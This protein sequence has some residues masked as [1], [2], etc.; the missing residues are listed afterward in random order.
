MKITNQTYWFFLYIFLIPGSLLK[1]YSQQLEK[2]IVKGTVLDA[3]TGDPL[4]FVSVILKNTTVGIVTDN[5]GRYIIETTVRANTVAYSF[6]GYETETR[7]I[8]YGQYQTIDISLKES[9]FSIN[10]VIVKPK[11][12]SYSNK[13]N[14][15]VELIQRVIEKKSEN[16]KEGFDY[17]KYEKYEKVQF[18]LSKTSEKDRERFVFKKFQF[19]FDNVDTT[20]QKGMEVLPF[21]IKEALSTCYYRKTPPANKEIVNGERTINFDEYIDNKGITAYLGY[22]YQNIN[23]YDNNILFLTNKFLSP[24]AQSAPLFYKY[25]IIDTVQL[26][27]VKCFRLFFDARNKADFLFQGFLYITQDSSYAIRKVDMNLNNGINI[28]WIKNVKIVQDF[29]QTKKKTWMLTKDDIS[30]NFEITEKVKGFYG[31]RTVSYTNWVLNES[32]NDSIFKGPE[33]I[34]KIDPDANSS[35]YWEMNRHIPLTKTEKGI[36]SNVDSIKQIPA[37]KPMMDVIMLL[38]TDFYPFKKAEIG[39]AGSFISFN[40]IEGN[41]LRFGG[42]TTPGFSKKITFDGYLAYGF[43][44]QQYKYSAGVTYSLTSRTIYQF[45]VKSIKL[46]YQYDTQIPGQDLQFAQSDNFFLSFKR[47]VDDKRLYNRTIRAEILNE[48]ENHFSYTLGFRYLKQTRGGNLF[49]NPVNYTDSI[50]SINIPEAYIS[51]RYAPNETFYQGK[52]DRG[53]VPSKYP[54]FI[55]KYAIGSK[56]LGNDYNYSRIQ[57]SVSRRFYPSILGYTYVTAEAG[58]IF[59]KVPF[60]LLF[61]HPANQTYSY[62]PGSYNLMNFLEFVSDEYVSLNVDH[63]FN[64]FFF[65]KVP[66]LKRLKFREIVTFKVLYG[67]VSNENDPS[68]PNGLFQFPTDKV[69]IDNKNVIVPLTY[70]LETKPYIEAGIGLSNILKIF[71]VDLIKRFTY[72]HTGNPNVPKLPGFRIQLRF[73]L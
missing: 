3:K 52:Q 45:P 6:L 60:P 21:F 4:P 22:L 69:E 35:A 41:R 24:I 10:E 40:T 20:K 57:F 42:R 39:P 67:G 13:N 36:Y 33:T 19:I 49:F 9:S 7:P 8:L 53:R 71:R 38:A 62:Q 48:F 46:N 32:L 63:S 31:E 43:K 68:K 64:G 47:G 2:T 18:A 25:Y 44:D 15:A 56:V 72:L 73:D 54:I 55:L 14:P 37:F 23:I 26:N 27:D 1:S 17:T 5:N 51:L 66:F 58:K 28:D 70:S 11:K 65:N 16:R 12:Q 50:Q 29:V 34:R 61:Q 59:G 30:I